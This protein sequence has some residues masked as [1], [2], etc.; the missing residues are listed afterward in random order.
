[1]QCKIM[2]K[3]VKFKDF[4]TEAL[5]VPTGVIPLAKQLFDYLIDNIENQDDLEDLVKFTIL[6][7]GNFSINDMKIKINIK[8]KDIT[9][10]KLSVLV[11]IDQLINKA[12]MIPKI[13][14]DLSKR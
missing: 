14:L 12:A 13:A 9:P 4:V 7:D 1:M 10:I 8:N 5:G 11:E 6:M 2:D 3:I